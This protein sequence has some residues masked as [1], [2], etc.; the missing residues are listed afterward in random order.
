ME[1]LFTQQA[2]P[3]AANITSKFDEVAQDTDQAPLLSFVTPTDIITE[4]VDPAAASSIR[5]W[6]SG[7]QQMQLQATESCE[8]IEGGRQHNTQIPEHEL[9][10]ADN[11][12]QNIGAWH[13]PEHRMRTQ[14]CE[15]FKQ[16]FNDLRLSELESA[17]QQKREEDEWVKRQND[18]VLRKREVDEEFVRQA[19]LKRSHDAKSLRQRQRYGFR[20][21]T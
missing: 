14:R 5:L 17:A 2:T 16:A 10:M 3:A 1:E 6:H 15:L 9:E 7:R 4:E 21:P 11:N 8:D 19:V 18:L 20:M 12:E 13:A